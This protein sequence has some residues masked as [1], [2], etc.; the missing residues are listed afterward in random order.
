MR[1]RCK[2]RNTAVLTILIEVKGTEPVSSRWMFRA[3]KSNC[4][5]ERFDNTYKYYACT[6]SVRTNTSGNNHAFK[7]ICVR[8][9]PNVIEI[10]HCAHYSFKAELQVHIR[11]RSKCALQ[12]MKSPL[13]SLYSCVENHIYNKRS[14]KKYTM[15]YYSYKFITNICIAFRRLN[16][17]KICKYLQCN[18]Y[19]IHT[20]IRHRYVYRP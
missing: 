17:N 20:S 7:Y 18:R 19:Y 11:Y 8:I 10:S 14:T 4:D 5:H 13:N 6:L 16:T 15:F 9:Y 2:S 1:F 12:P 3:W